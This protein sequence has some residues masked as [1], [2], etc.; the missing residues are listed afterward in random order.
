ML[1]NYSSQKLQPLTDDQIRE[2]APSVFASEAWSG[3]SDKYSFVPTATVVSGMRDNGWLPVSA[4]QQL[5]RLDSRR[6]FQKHI[7]RF[8]RADQFGQVLDYRPEICLVNAH[9]RS[10]AYQ[11]HAGLF[12]LVCRNGLVVA[13]TTFEHISV[14]HVGFSPDQVIDA[15]FRVLEN[16]PQLAENVESFR[17]RQLTTTEQR[18]FAEAA[19]LLKYDDLQTAPISPEKLL[20]SRRYDDDGNDLWRT[21]NRVQEN[22]IR[23]GLK[24]WSRRKANGKRHSRTRPVTG[25][26]E[27]VKLNKAL[28]HLAETLKNGV[29]PAIN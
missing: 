10:S 11:L 13:D 1:S 14:R 9:D 2:L 26:D 15:S 18:A 22:L 19:T 24:D 23:G 8:Q 12:R 4:K 27:N 5:V 17:A 16:I 25:I 3:V 20:V 7:I 6:G 29:S 28:W 21:Y